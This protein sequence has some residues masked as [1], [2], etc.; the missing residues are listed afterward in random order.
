MK[1]LIMSHTRYDHITQGKRWFPQNY[2]LPVAGNIGGFLHDRFSE[3]TRD[4][5]VD[6]LNDSNE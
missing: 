4:D 6:E 2:K 3:L 1:V 5:Q